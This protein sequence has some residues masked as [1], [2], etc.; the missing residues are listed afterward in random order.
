MW[1]KECEVETLVS[2]RMAGIIKA[3]G[4]DESPKAIVEETG[5]VFGRY[6]TVGTTKP[7]ADR[8]LFIPS[9]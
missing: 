4:D 9:F 7:I 1:T 3:R 6:G 8:R 2:G 5:T